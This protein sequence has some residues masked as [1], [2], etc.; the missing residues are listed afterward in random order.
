MLPIGEV[1]VDGGDMGMLTGGYELLR[2]S[3][4]F[5]RSGLGNADLDM[6]C[7][8]G[9]GDGVDVVE[10]KVGQGSMEIGDHA[11]SCKNGTACSKDW[12]GFA[13]EFR[14]GLGEAMVGDDSCG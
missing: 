10:R 1:A 9:W 14:M 8:E 2:G 13:A 4:G 11:W 6:A 7:G 5:D 3:I 12:V